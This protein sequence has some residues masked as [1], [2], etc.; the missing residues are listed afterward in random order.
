M[1]DLEILK[2]EETCTGCGACASICPVECIE[3]G[4]NKEGFYYPSVDFDTCIDCKKCDKNCHA[5][6][7]DKIDTVQEYTSFMVWSNQETIRNKST[8][9]GMFTILANKILETDGVV[10]GARYNY[11]KER[12]EHANSDDFDLEEFRKSK[13]IESDTL[14]TFNEVKVFLKEKRKVLYCGAPCQIEGLIDFLGKK[15]KSPN[16]LLVDFICHG[17]P[18]N[19]HFTEYKHYVENKVKAKITHLDFRPKNKEIKWGESRL[20][21]QFNNG[22]TITETHPENLY[23]TAFYKN[24][25][26]RKVCYKCDIVSKHKA[27]ITLGDFWGIRKYKP[28]LDN[29][30]GISLV[31]INNNRGNTVFESLNSDLFFK[32]KLP[33]SASEYAYNRN[34]ERFAES[35]KI[36]DYISDDVINKGYLY[37]IRN[38]HQKDIAIYKTKRIIKEVL[39]KIGIFKPLEKIFRK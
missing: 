23:Y 18:S 34:D 8:S 26:L 15:A 5:L 32:E 1:I 6:L 37:P 25:F 3:M 12:L 20:L 33:K 9:G 19:K 27:D 14:N 30:K 10:F 22:K 16:L 35:R 7:E 4:Y 17:V 2:I 28:E 29:G 13:Y 21:F 36:R 24:S 38:L 39:T 31:N 11:E